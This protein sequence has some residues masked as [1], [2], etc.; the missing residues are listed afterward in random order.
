MH[1]IQSSLVIS[2]QRIY[3]TIR[4][5]ANVSPRDYVT[6]SL[7][8]RMPYSLRRVLALPLVNIALSQAMSVS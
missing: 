2:C 4:D 1:A 3:N 8:V 7:H 6:I 5:T